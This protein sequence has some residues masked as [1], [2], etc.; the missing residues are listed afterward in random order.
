MKQRLLAW[1]AVLGMA[2]ALPALGQT[3]PH[4]TAAE[5]SE[6]YSGRALLIMMDGKV[7]FERY[8]DGW[9]ADKPHL[10]ASGTKSFSGVMAAAAIQD[11]IIPGWDDVVS[12]TI[13]E[14]KADSQKAKITL[15]MLLDLSS[16][17]NPNDPALESRGGGRLLGEGAARRS[18]RIESSGVEEAGDKYSAAL[19]TSMVGTPGGQFQYGSAHFHA[20]GAYMTER[21]KLAGR[22]ETTVEQYFIERIAKPAGFGVAF[23]TKDRARN[24]NLPGGALL[25]AREWAKFGEFVRLGGAVRQADGSLKQ[26]VDAGLLAECFKPSK[27][28]AAYG[29]TW[30]LPGSAG[31]ATVADGGGNINERLRQ[32]MVLAQMKPALEPDGSAIEVYMAAGLGKQRLMILPKYRMVIVRFAESTQAGMRYDDAELIRLILGR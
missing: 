13:T 18:Q 28:N 11:G 31:D 6:S 22:P 24:I 16:G 1:A 19:K 4:E 10:L 15:R 8:A 26:I 12:D 2:W 25:T 21:L 27:N 23:W 32:Q 7:V 14:W 20:F 5:Y 30:W 3:M 29:L 9:H 17:L